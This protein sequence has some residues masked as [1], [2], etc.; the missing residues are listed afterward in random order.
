[1]QSL[2]IKSTKKHPEKKNQK[3]TLKTQKV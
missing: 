3:Q 1:M 2:R